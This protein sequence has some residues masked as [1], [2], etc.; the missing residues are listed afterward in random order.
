MCLCGQ[1]GGGGLGGVCLCGQ[2][3]G[4]VEVSH[5]FLKVFAV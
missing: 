2:V 1:V 3:G 4:E 5:E